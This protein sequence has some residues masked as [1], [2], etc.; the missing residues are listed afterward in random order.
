MSV[1][2]YAANINDTLKNYV[3][4]FGAVADF[5]PL[6][7]IRRTE[8]SATTKLSSEHESPPIENMLLV[9]ALLSV[10]IV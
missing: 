1:L 4:R 6:N 8:L 5:S 10:V 7:F 2:F 9:A 3:L